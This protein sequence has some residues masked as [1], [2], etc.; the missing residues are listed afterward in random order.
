MLHVI[1]TA[2]VQTRGGPTTVRLSFL[3]QRSLVKKR[4]IMPIQQKAKEDKCHTKLILAG[5]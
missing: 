5:C 4:I 1:I 3:K 2:R